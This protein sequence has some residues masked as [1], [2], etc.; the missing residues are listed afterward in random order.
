MK[1]IKR[2][3]NIIKKDIFTNL[4]VIFPTTLIKFLCNLLQ[5]QISVNESLSMN[6]VCNQIPEFETTSSI[7]GVIPT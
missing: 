4:V 5:M 3:L 2:R 6:A 1:T 7:L